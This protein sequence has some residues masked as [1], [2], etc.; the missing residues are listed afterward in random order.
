MRITVIAKWGVSWTIKLNCLS[1][2]GTTLQAFFATAVG[3]RGDLSTQRHFSDQSPRTCGVDDLIA[4]ANLYLALQDYKH[5]IA[6]FTFAE[7][8]RTRFI[9]D[10]ILGPA[11]K[12]ENQHVSASG[13]FGKK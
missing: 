12:I 6:W 11:K 9:G 3:L 5:R 1:L 7:N 8:N 2:T 13:R 10:R 4:D